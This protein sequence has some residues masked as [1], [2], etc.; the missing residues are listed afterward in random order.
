M[1]TQVADMMNQIAASEPVSSRTEESFAVLDVA[2]MN[3]GDGR[4]ELDRVLFP[5]RVIVGTE[6]FPSRIA[7]NWALVRANPHLLGDFVWAGWD[8]LGEAGIGAIAHLEPGEEVA[9]AAAQPYPWLVA[10]TG[11][12][13]ITG[14]RR[15]ASY[16]RE[17]VF[18]LRSEPYIAVHRPQNHGKTVLAGAWSWS[19]AISSWS[20]DGFEGNPTRVEVYSDAD[21]VELRVNGRVLGR[22]AVGE[23]LAF[24][25]D[26]DVTYEPGEL[27]AVAYSG[28]LERGRAVVTTPSDSLVLTV[29]A[30]RTSIRA[31]ST[32]AAFLA[33][34]LTDGEGN[35]HSGRDR[36][37]SVEV[38]G[39]A[40]L[41]ALGSG[42]PATEEDFV[43]DSRRTFDGRALAVV[44]PTGEGGIT[45]TVRADG[46]KPVVVPLQAGRT[47]PV[48]VVAGS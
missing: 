4:Y 33:I 22:A 40:V 17:T 1:M 35:L 2:G 19:D 6:T 5:N 9:P 36:L 30:D 14:H 25:A 32:D 26:F 29:D 11:D 3:Y 46:C 27:V 42:D 18:G 45:V 12:I 37:V 43:S 28:G 41:Q 13:D 10:F 38:E 21:E 20:W 7:G 44:R 15:P 47:A 8:Y 39:P 48:S 31:D 34:S 16:Y 23:Q 24:R